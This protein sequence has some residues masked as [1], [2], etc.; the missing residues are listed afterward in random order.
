MPAR[1]Y[2]KNWYVDFYYENKRIRLKS[3]VQTKRGTEEYERKLRQNLLTEKT[4]NTTETTKQS[5][6][7]TP[8]FKTFATKWLKTYP[9]VAG[10]K[11]SEQAAKTS[12]MN[13]HL[14]PTF[15]NLT[16]DNINPKRIDEFTANLIGKGKTPK[17]VANILGVLARCLRSAVEWEDLNKLPVIKKPCVPPPDYDWLTRQESE[18]LLASAR[19][20]EDHT[21]LLFALDT[22]CRAGEQLAIRWGQ[23][24]LTNK[25]VLIRRAV[26]QGHEGTPKAHKRREV[27][28]THRLE[29]AL[30]KHKHLK[31][32]YVFCNPD[33]TPLTI[34]QLQYVL[35]RTLQHARLREVTWHALRHS[36]ASQL[37]SA[38]ISLRVVQELLGHS[39]IRTTMRYAH[40]APGLY[41]DAVAVLDGEK[42]G[43]YLGTQ[44]HTPTQPPELTGETW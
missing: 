3:P 24:D 30:K 36:F 11:P 22:G 33:G 21:T 19:D 43:H 27:P 37:V 26:W 13:N 32:P 42:T 6:K 44:Q 14:I 5:R 9:T 35:T 8:T 31:G 34:W 23:I 17:T 41:R 2:R 18:H 4:S 28:L 10:N 12:I 7:E 29:N 20:H 16:L 38:G 15:G 39:D 25:K 40:L 1:K